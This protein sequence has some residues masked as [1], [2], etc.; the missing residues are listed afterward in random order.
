AAHE[1]SFANDRA[2]AWQAHEATL[3]RLDALSRLFDI[4]FEIPGTNVRF[5]VEAILRFVPGFGDVAASAPC[6]RR[7]AVCRRRVQRGVPRQPSQ[8]APVARLFRRTRL[9][10]CVIPVRRFVLVPMRHA[11]LVASARRWAAP[12]DNDSGRQASRL[13]HRRP[14]YTTKPESRMISIAG[15]RRRVT[16]DPR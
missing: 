10:R 14:P 2:Y 15:N 12:V 1:F 4:T 11:L 5:G 13:G 6:R 3:A 16:P 9:R 8:C 7:R